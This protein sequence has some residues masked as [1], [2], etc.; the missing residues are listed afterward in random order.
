MTTTE[1]V[2]LPG[3]TVGGTEGRGNVVRLLAALIPRH[4]V[5]RMSCISQGKAWEY[6][7]HFMRSNINHAE[8]IIVTRLLDY[9]I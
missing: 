8:R 5:L 3:R 2:Y 6:L 4:S 7:A 1:L 9:S